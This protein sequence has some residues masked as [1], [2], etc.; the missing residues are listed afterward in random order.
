MYYLPW[1]QQSS[2]IATVC[3]DNIGDGNKANQQHRSGLSS[4]SSTEQVL[5]LF[6]ILQEFMF[7]TAARR[8]SGT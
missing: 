2:N 3:G 5:K 1:I 8:Q 4:L 6:V 7:P